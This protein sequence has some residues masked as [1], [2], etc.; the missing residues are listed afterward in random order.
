MKQKYTLT[1]AD[2]QINVVTDAPESSIEH[3][4]GILDRKVR[5]ILLKS[6]RCSRNEAALLCALDFCAD[7]IQLK[8]ELDEL[9]GEL[10]GVRE[11]L[12]ASAQSVLQMIS[13]GIARITGSLAGG[14]ICFIQFPAPMGM[15][16][17][18]WY[19]GDKGKPHKYLFYGLYLAQLVVFGLL[20]KMI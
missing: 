2:M 8:D 1:I 16:P 9:A 12:Q 3:I 13:F 10:E 20:A 7:K 19:D 11:E 4:V 14:L 6:K 15:F 18:H 5:D 17:V